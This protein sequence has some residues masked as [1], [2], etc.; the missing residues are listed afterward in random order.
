[1]PKFTSKLGQ[2]YYIKK[3]RNTK[4]PIISCHGGP[5]GTH[6]SVKPLLDLDTKRTVVVY[7]QIGAGL[8]SSLDKRKWKIETFCQNLDELIKHL[9]FS[10]VILHGSSWGGTLILEYFKR[11]PKKVK[12]LIF[13][14]SLISSTDWVKDAKRL[15]SKLPK[16]T[17]QVIKACEEVGATD[18]QV[19][20][21]AITAY[22]K[23]HVCRVNS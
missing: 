1:M 15:I 5:G 23:K 7:D 20:K 14:S 6:A 19:Y 16:R 17:Q 8:S 18:S 4:T 12:G 9:G 22:Y 21:D 10:E 3:G 11:H 13:H 2:T